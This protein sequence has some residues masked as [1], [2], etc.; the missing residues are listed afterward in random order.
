MRR[1]LIVILTIL[2]LILPTTLFTRVML[3]EAAPI[4]QV[5]VL[6]LF[7]EIEDR[8]A[9]IEERQAWRDVLEMMNCEYVEMKNPEREKYF[10]GIRVYDNYETTLACLFHRNPPGHIYETPPGHVNPP[11]FEHYTN[12]DLAPLV[13]KS[14]L[15]VHDGYDPH[16]HDPDSPH[17][18]FDEEQPSE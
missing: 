4:Q 10:N 3:L 14:Q 17:L 18:H 7:G 12:V 8:L 6:S 15:H 9:K 2:L 5:N 13:Q 11:G 16:L 1:L